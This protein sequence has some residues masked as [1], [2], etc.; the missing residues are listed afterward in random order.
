MKGRWALVALAGAQ[1][2]MVLDQSVMNV[3]ISQLV[4]EFDTTVTTIQAVITLYCLVM[5]M[6]M[7]TGGKIGDIIGRRRAFVI[8]LVIYAC[9]SAMT[10]VAPTVAILTLGWSVLEGL[11]AAL[12]L[13][14]MAALIAGNF[15]G[16]ERK[17]AYAVIGGVAGAGIA[18]GPILGGWA[19]T[20]LSWRIVFVGEVVI[21]LGILAMT[22]FIGDAPRS[23]PKPRLDVVGTILSATGLGA[24]VLGV[25]QSTT[26]G[27]LEPKDSPIEPF[28][29]SVTLFVI[30]AGAALL[31]AF[32]AWQRHREASGNDPLVHFDL[33]KI[34]PLRAG[35]IGLF[36][37][38]LILMG[39]FFTIPLYLQLVL[40]LNALETGLKM[41]PVSIAM[42][43]A[44]AVGSRLTI[45]FPVRSITRAGLAVT[46]VAAFALLATIRPDLADLAFAVSMALLGVGMGLI[47]SQLGN[48]V[49]S[50]VDAS[51]RG[52]AGGLQ[53]TGQQLGSSLGVALVGAIVLAGLTSTFVTTIQADER[54]SDQVA[55]QVGVA[56]ESGLDFVSSADIEAAAQEAGL[57][58]ATTQAI[59]DDYEDAQLRSLKV[60]LLAAAFIAFASLA[61]TKNLPSHVPTIE[62]AFEGGEAAAAGGAGHA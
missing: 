23:G 12:V 36:S 57:D 54:I 53:Y 33:V 3:S 30:G 16:R 44:S 34:P 10:A 58:A 28:G 11:G 50:S 55:A 48:V 18:I 29:F 51:G 22:R 41:L 59:V 20:E 21:V 56:V 47:A 39:V 7:L 27:W 49:Q 45:R 31:W 2:I 8:G 1:F 60:G 6:F 32:V 42:F 24:I 46:G 38:N 19:T 62:A 40:G 4:D 52:E 13:P 35:L 61:F 37:Q 14:A 43:L 17:V 9:G 25:L 5:A 26:W 15:E